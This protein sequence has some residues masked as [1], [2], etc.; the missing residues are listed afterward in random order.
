MWMRTA[1]KTTTSNDMGSIICTAGATGEEEKK[2]WTVFSSS[3]RRSIFV[4][5]FT[6]ISFASSLLFVIVYSKDLF[7]LRKIESKC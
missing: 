6:C 4:G 5:I 2:T 7:Y 3:E 1:K